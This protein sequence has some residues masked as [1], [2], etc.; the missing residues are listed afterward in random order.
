LKPTVITHENIC[1]VN[2]RI[3]TTAGN[4]QRGNLRRGQ[5]P[6][7]FIIVPDRFTFQAEKI[8]GGGLLNT[9]VL[10]FTM[11]YH[12]LHDTDETQIL[13]K[14][15]AVLL[16]WRA[17]RL[18]Q[19]DLQY[20]ARMT[21]HYAFSEKMFNTINQLTSCMADFSTLEKNACTP[22]TKRKMHDISI[23]YAKYKELCADQIDGP[24]T[25]AWLIENVGKHELVRL[26][27]FYIT[28]FPYLS[29][30]RGE[31]I[32]QIMQNAKS[33]TIGAQS[34]GEFEGFINEIRYTM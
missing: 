11:L 30:E 2:E 22:I 13:D 20:F 6:P 25:L 9:R 3:L 27:N 26:A 7:V 29:K 4:Y 24:K 5:I 8:L 32:R 34:G 18:V 10:T 1:D 19:N 28:G 14:N 17:I 21:H 15:S 33:C 31:V 12:L 16:M 23:I